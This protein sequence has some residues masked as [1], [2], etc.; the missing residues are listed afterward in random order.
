MRNPYKAFLLSLL[1][2][3]SSTSTTNEYEIEVFE[4]YIETDVL[5]SIDTKLIFNIEESNDQINL[6][7][8]SFPKSFEQIQSYSLV[9]DLKFRENY[10]TDTQSLCVG[11]VW[12]KFGPG[13]VSIELKKNNN[14]K[15]SVSGVIN[16]ENNG[17]GVFLY[18]SDK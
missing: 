7:V 15:N 6:Q 10:E 17:N 9:F 8:Q 1:I 12:D 16:P 4:S 13:E 14:F 5:S 3:C 11:P 18:F 2:F